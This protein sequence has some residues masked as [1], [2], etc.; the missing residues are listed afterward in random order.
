MTSRKR[1]VLLTAGL[2]ALLLLV[3]VA[4]AAQQTR[5]EID[6]PLAVDSSAPGGSRA[7][8][9]WLGELGY[10][11]S[12][13]VAQAFTIPPSAG[14]AMM[15][16]PDSNQDPGQWE[17]YEG[18]VGDGGTLLVGGEGLGAALAARHF[19]FDLLLLPEATPPLRPQTPLF[20]SPPL[21]EAA[22]VRSRAYFQSDRSDYLVHLAVGD[23]PVLVSFELGEGRVFL[24]A[25]A[26][27]FSNVGLGEQGNAALILNLVGAGREGLIWFDE[28]HHGRRPEATQLEGLSDWLTKTPGGRSLLY[29]ASVIFLAIVLSGRRFGR[30][31]PPPGRGP[32]R[33]PLEYVSAMANLARRARH[34]EAVRQHYHDRLKRG[35]G[36]RYRL[37]P[38]T[39]D[40]EFVDAL[41]RIRADLDARTLGE[42][43]ETLRRSHLG[44]RELTLAAARVAE[45]LEEKPL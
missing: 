42:L 4:A 17:L 3:S 10:E 11:V 29:A 30:A 32:R 20:R 25:T 36:Q 44:D 19:G 41:A 2:T 39:A 34:G 18:W 27:P 23:A 24:S 1:D 9:L 37:D 12:S 43:L 16:E 7:L 45:F 13:E 6:P 22:D 5:Q 14:L 33:P 31:V 26:F 40:A 21:I 28:W 8:S 15:L 35:L 38:S